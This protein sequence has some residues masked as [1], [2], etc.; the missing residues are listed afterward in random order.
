[1][2]PGTKI[3]GASSKKLEVRVVSLKRI[4]FTTTRRHGNLRAPGALARFLKRKNLP[5]SFA[6]AEQIHN[7]RLQRVPPLRHS[8]R[9]LRVDGLFTDVVDQPLAIFTADCVP[10]FLSADHDRVVGLL[11]A[12]WRGV[13]GRILARAIKFLRLGWRLKPDQ[14]TAW[15]GPGIGPCCFAIRW[16]VARY[17]PST[18]RRFEGQWQVDLTRELARQAR[19]LGIRWMRKNGFESCTMHEARFFSFRRNGTAERQV[20]IILKREE[21]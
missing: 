7:T 10:V 5:C 8:K 21:P 14:I 16:D 4:A 12:G 11:H 19:H 18:R 6:W 1:L 15:A 3:P 13:H 17:F 2:K 20:S 9:F